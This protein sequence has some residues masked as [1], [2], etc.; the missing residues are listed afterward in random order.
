MHLL[1][2]YTTGGGGDL[3]SLVKTHHGACA[4]GGEGEGCFVGILAS[5]MK[6][7]KMISSNVVGMVFGLI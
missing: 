2:G 4:K 1:K 7:P 3:A 6:F 5:R